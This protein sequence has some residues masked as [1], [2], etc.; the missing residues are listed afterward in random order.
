[1]QITDVTSPELVAAARAAT[2][3]PPAGTRSLSLSHRAARFGA[4]PAA[5][6][7]AA[8]QEA[9]VVA[10]LES[11]AGLAALDALLAAPAQPDAW[12]LGPMDLSADL[13]HPGDLSHPEVAGALDRAL[14]AVLAAG[15]T[16]GAFAGASAAAADWRARGARLLVVS[17]DVALLAS[18]AR[19]LSPQHQEQS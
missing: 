19:S 10:Q 1:V 11:R 13:G 12:F 15:A 6:A 3:F 17:S 4:V 14:Q 18:A 8:A 9:V 5:E 7:V 16:A 2:A